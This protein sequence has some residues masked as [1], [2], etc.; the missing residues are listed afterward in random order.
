M[1]YHVTEKEQVV[2]ILKGPQWQRTN[3]GSLFDRGSADSYYSRGPDPHWYPEGTGNGVKVTNLTDEERM[4]Y[5]AG[6]T[7]NERHGGKKEWN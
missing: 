7:Y 6:Y 1:S 5:M 4:E 2:R 3:H